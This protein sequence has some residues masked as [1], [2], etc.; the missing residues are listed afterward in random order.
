MDKSHQTIVVYCDE[1]RYDNAPDNLY[2]GIGGIWIPLSER[3]RFRKS[4]KRLAA[5]YHLNSEIKWSKTSDIVLPG[6]K[7]F[8]DAFFAVDFV[9][10]RIILVN[11]DL[12]D[13]K[14]FQGGD[15]ELGFYRFY[16]HMLKHWIEPDTDYNILL[17][18]K[19]NT[20]VGRYA[21]VKN[22]L[23]KSAPTTTGIKLSVADSKE[24]HIAQL[25]DLLVG[26]ETAAWCETKEESAKYYLQQHIAQKLGRTSLKFI[27]STPQIN[28]YNIFMIQ[29]SSPAQRDGL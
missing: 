4:L 22:T 11:H 12:L 21:Q 20:R 25:T 15:S 26:A 13:Y 17:D 3:N 6:Y 28:K 23:I 2:M 5:D 16:Y 9:Q 1:S 29:L 14:S 27:S 7:A 8:I 18:H 10:F 24:S 19:I